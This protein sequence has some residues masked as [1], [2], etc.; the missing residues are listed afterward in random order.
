[1]ANIE[2]AKAVLSAHVEA[3]VRRSYFAGLSADERAGHTESQGVAS[4]VHGNPVLVLDD[5]ANSIYVSTDSRELA[6]NEEASA[7]MRKIRTVDG[8]KR[9]AW[10][11]LAG[12]DASQ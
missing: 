3:L 7:T 2:D 1:R 9:E 10:G 12:N 5:R 11:Q 8:I 6:A 4:L